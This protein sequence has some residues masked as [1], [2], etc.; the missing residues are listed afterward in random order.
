LVL[1]N[2]AAG[3]ALAEVEEESAMNGAQALGELLC[4]G[5]IPTRH[6]DANAMRRQSARHMG[7]KRAVAANY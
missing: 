5:R 2:G 6:D 7:T 1:E 3:F 4:P